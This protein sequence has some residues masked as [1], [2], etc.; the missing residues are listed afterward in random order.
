MYNYFKEV[1]R[2]KYQNTKLLQY[3]NFICGKTVSV[4]GI[5]ISN[6]PL[7]DFLLKCGARVTARD[8]KPICELEKNPK[9][10]T[11]ALQNAGVEFVTGENYLENL[12]QEVIFKSPGI[13]FDKPE[14]LKAYQN[15]SIITSEMEAFISLCPATIVAITGSDGKTT[16]TTLAAKL[17]EA[18]GKTVYLGG[19]IGKPLLCEI[20]NIKPSDFV[21]LE[22]SSFQLHTVNRFENKDFPF[23][24]LEFPDV[25]IITNVTPN[26]LNWHTDMQEYADSKSAIFKYM[27]KGGR[28]IANN[29]SE[30][31][32]EYREQTT[33][34][35]VN[36]YT[37]SA[38]ESG[39]N[40][41]LKDDAIYF[42]G[43]KVVDRNDILL[44]GVHNIEN[45][46]A[47]IGATY[48]FITKEAIKKVA[49]TFGGVEHRLELVDNKNGVKYYNGS[50]DST[51][52]RTL[53][54][55]SCFGKEYDG[56][57][58]LLLGGKDKNLDF[59]EL[60]KV[61]CQ[62]VK[63]VFISHDTPEKKVENAI[64]NSKGFDREKV[65]VS[66]ENGFDAAVAAA[67]EYAQ[68]GDIVLL[69]PAMTSFDEFSNFEERGRRFKALV[70]GL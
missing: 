9:L 55:I 54:A 11:K 1:D 57:I 29:A 44:P 66:V 67:S 62:R 47:A 64:K 59:E 40:V 42:D 19:N 36:L 20:E 14:I 35:N 22:L 41:Y 24:H 52:S 70:K 48:E 26:H 49:T 61:I 28:L 50:I 38:K 4:I 6:I 63:A 53:A 18:A 21:V 10:D 25:A 60:A 3:K 45:Y 37:F 34:Q 68:N 15:G 31:L 16:T 58:V 65:F 46:M 8:L 69:S 7:I 32:E 30:Y 39:A 23:A 43:E 51:P 27:K 17:L 2:V 33:K 13:R 56:K 5:G 12:S